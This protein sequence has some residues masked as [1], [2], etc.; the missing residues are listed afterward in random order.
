IQPTTGS[1]GLVAPAGLIGPAGT[2]MP[3]GL[4]VPAGLAV[5]VDAAVFARSCRGTNLSVSTHV[6]MMATESLKRRAYDARYSFPATT[7]SA[8]PRISGIFFV[9][10]S[11]TMSRFASLTLGRNTASSKS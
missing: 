7:R 1:K 8:R 5:L 2:A 10:L 11:D 9:H 4:A 6:G 3:G